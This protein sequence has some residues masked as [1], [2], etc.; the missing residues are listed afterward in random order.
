MPAPRN[1][2]PIASAVVWAKS[3]PTMMARAVGNNISNLTQS[4]VSSITYRVSNEVGDVTVDSGSLTASAVIFNTLQTD[5]RWTF[6]STGY[7]F[8]YAMNKN[9]LPEAGVFIATFM[10][11]PTTGEQ[12]P[13]VFRLDAQDPHI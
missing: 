1:L 3:G 8:R 2:A 13:I 11:V 12:F 7:N 5:D 4:T 10:I 9:Q 6:D